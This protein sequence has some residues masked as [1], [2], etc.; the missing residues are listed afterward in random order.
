MAKLQLSYNNEFRRFTLRGEYNRGEDAIYEMVIE[1]PYGDEWR[2][3]F[4]RWDELDD[5][6]E[7]ITRSDLKQRIQDVR[8]HEGD[9]VANIWEVENTYYVLRED[10]PVFK[11]QRKWEAL[12]E[13]N[14]FDIPVEW[15]EWQGKPMSQEA[16]DAMADAHDRE[17]QACAAEM[18]EAIEA[19]GPTEATRDPDFN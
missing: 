15:H 19:E 4:L 3:R 13:L 16:M 1:R 5:W 14:I 6:S 9:E 10:H 17:M 18:A 7:C 2:Y 8:D 12:M 11:L